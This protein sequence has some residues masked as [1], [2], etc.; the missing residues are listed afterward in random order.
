LAAIAGVDLAFI[1]SPMVGGLGTNAYKAHM[2][3]ELKK[4]ANEVRARLHE[5]Y[6]KECGANNTT[7]EWLD[8]DGDPAGALQ[9]A[10]ESCD[11]VVT[12]HD[13]AFHGRIR[14]R[15]PDMLAD[16]MLTAP[17]PLIVCGDEDGGDGDVMIAYD[18]SRPAI[19]AVQ[20]FALLGLGA[21]HRI[22]LVAIGSDK[23]SAARLPAGAARYLRGR[24]CD[25]EVIPI[26]TRAEPAE[27]LRIEV[28]ARKISTLVMGVYG[29][30]GL[31]ERLFGSTTTQLLEEPPCALFVYH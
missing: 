7:F 30:R 21:R 20:L 2:E 23:A 1:E 13:T 17:R 4:Q 6:A 27:A 10:A 5:A 9:T 26:A 22:Y 29:H 24:G 19:R 14:E 16:L 8:F 3:A 11:V 25:V 15:L 18:G 31:R 12:G 28:A